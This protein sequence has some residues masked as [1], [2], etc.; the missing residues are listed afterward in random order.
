MEV[1]L[2][3]KL[4]L[5]GE[6]NEDPKHR[7]RS[8]KA[9]QSGGAPGLHKRGT[10]AEDWGESRDGRAAPSLDGTGAGGPPNETSRCRQASIARAQDSVSCRDDGWLPNGDGANSE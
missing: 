7:G 8:V 6:G 3:K 1:P 5:L 9:D 2:S 10:S 4:M